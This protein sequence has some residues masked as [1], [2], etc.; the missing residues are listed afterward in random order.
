[1]SANGKGVL[2]VMARDAVHADAYR[3][4]HGV[5]DATPA[6]LLRESNEAHAHAA[7]LRDAVD[8]WR[9][10][11]EVANVA[12]DVGDAMRQ[13]RLAENELLEAFRRFDG[14]AE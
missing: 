3:I 7:A 9:Y 14:G 11:R 10:A 12:R 5:I 8:Q 2:A 1:M 4:A 6:E 13:V